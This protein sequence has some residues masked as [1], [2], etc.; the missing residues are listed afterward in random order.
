MGRNDFWPG[1]L[2]AW[3]GYDQEVLLQLPVGVHITA[4]IATRNH[5]GV[6]ESSEATRATPLLI[7]DGEDDSFRPW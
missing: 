1:A 4:S 6:V 7:L 2:L 3:E 5:L